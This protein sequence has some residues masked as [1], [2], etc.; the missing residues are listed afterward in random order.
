MW[1]CVEGNDKMTK[2][3]TKYKV[4]HSLNGKD[5]TDVPGEYN[6]TDTQTDT[7]TSYFPTPVSAQYVRLV[8]IDWYGTIHMRA[9][10]LLCRPGPGPNPHVRDV[11]VSDMTEGTCS[12]STTTAGVRIQVTQDTCWQHVH[13]DTLNVYDFS[14]VSLT[15]C[16]SS[17]KVTAFVRNPMNAI[18]ETGGHV[19]QYP[20]TVDDWENIKFKTASVSDPK[21]RILT[22]VGRFGDSIQ[23]RNLE[24]DL[25][26]LPMAD[27]LGVESTESTVG[28][29]ACGSRGEGAN[30]PLRGG[31]FFMI[32]VQCKDIRLNRVDRQLDFFYENLQRGK[33]FTFTNVALKSPDQLRQRV[34]W[35]LS[36]ILVLSQPVSLSHVNLIRF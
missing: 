17:S 4:Q 11:V 31:S 29:D 23:F 36:Q 35:A 16:P 34:A 10:L 25:Q 6:G 14:E 26:T 7:K 13:P 3:V 2:F 18:A 21:P 8:V 12:T 1:A 28:F 19:Y 20:G 15:H 9:D 5:W 30:N 27:A 22:Y 33:E 32:D 24:P